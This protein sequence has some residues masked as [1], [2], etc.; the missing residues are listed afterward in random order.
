MML[1]HGFARWIGMA[2]LLLALLA[3]RG[4]GAAATATADDHWYVLSL[5]GTPIGWTRSSSRPLA[6]PATPTGETDASRGTEFSRSM[7]LRLRRADSVVNTGSEITLI[8]DASGHL[9]TVRMITTGNDPSARTV[10]RWRFDASAVTETVEQ[11]GRTASRERPR[12]S[13]EWLAPSAVREL[14]R[15]RLA[16]GAKSVVYRTI[17]PQ[18]G[19]DAF[20]VTMEFAGEERLEVRGRLRPVTRW[21]VRNGSTPGISSD[22]WLSAD[23]TMVRERTELPIGVMEVVLADEAAARAAVG[24][25]APEIMVRTFV[26][27]D[28]PLRGARTLR[29]A[30][31]RVRI[32]DGMERTLPSAGAQVVEDDERDGWWRVTLDLDRPALR[33]TGQAAD[34]A[35]PDADRAADPVADPTDPTDPTDPADRAD[36]RPTDAD[37]IASA[38]LDS[39]DPAVRALVAAA[40]ANVPASADV[41]R[42]AE[43]LRQHVRR[44]ISEVGLGQLFASASETARHG[45]GDCSEHA[46]LLAAMLRAADVPARVAVGLVYADA[47]AGE[48]DVFGWHMWTQAWTGERWLDLDATLQ[49]PFDAA[50]LLIGVDSMDAG[51]SGELSSLLVLVG[52]LELEVIEAESRR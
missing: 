46:M 31:Y 16:A 6:R 21:T 24:G 4:A 33:R 34:E 32:P 12:P 27:P 7:S 1:P 17:D 28:R 45:R 40:L 5:D 43:A 18:A 39:D 15:S 9:R 38:M 36:D 51:G 11:V 41:A 25:E 30:V 14:V 48:R 42:R 20:D 35:D 23:G 2:G 47:F 22:Q 13:G 19:L 26:T 29:R 49:R 37:R 10:T 8:E 50:H 3:G 52:A 44:H